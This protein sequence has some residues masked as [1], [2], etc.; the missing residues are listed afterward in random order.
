[1]ASLEDKPPGSARGRLIVVLG[2]H[3]SG[4]SAITR[5]LRVF[6][7][8]LGDRLMPAEDMNARGFWEDVDLHE[9]NIDMLRAIRTEWSD[10]VRLTS[11]DLAVLRNRGYYEKAAA[12][13]RQK[14]GD[15]RLYGF[16]DPRVAKLLPFW[17]GVFEEACFDVSYVLQVRHPSSV[18]ASLSKRDQIDPAKSY[19][20]WLGYVLETLKAIQGHKCVVVDFDCLMR[21]PEHEVERIACNL[22]LAIN[23]VELH[24]YANNFLDRALRHSLHDLSELDADPACPRLVRDV[25]AVLLDLA[26]DRRRI[27]DGELPRVL[28]GWEAEFNRL[29]ASR[30]AY[31]GMVANYVRR[32][33]GLVLW[34]KNRIPRSVRIWLGRRL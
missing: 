34:L 18:V 31:L 9:L 24:D 5:A 13:L 14:I 8:E 3:R 25:Y 28:P 32:Q 27:D 16:K 15:A 2:M 20:L 11:G 6:G 19:L 23:P 21:S 1:M 17:G 10:T 12:L 29:C 7:V 26:T 30:W 33:G 4:T 22:D